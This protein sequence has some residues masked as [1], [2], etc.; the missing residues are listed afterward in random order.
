L[1]F[2]GVSGLLLVFPILFIELY[3]KETFLSKVWFE[4]TW[5]SVFWV[6]E[7]VSASLITDQSNTHLCDDQLQLLATN[8]NHTSPCTSA[9]VL[10]AFT[11]ICAILVFG[12]LSLLSISTIL[13]HKTDPAIF[14]CSVRK[15]PWL[16]VGLR[17]LSST[18]Q[19]PSKDKFH[20]EEPRIVAPKPQRLTI[21]FGE[22]FVA[23]RRGISQEYAIDNFKFPAHVDD[24]YE[25]PGG[26]SALSP[27]V[28]DI[29][30]PMPVATT[31][32]TMRAG[33]SA[34]AYH[35]TREA[36]NPEPAVMR[37]LAPV[38][39]L[40]A[41]YPSYVQHVPVPQP[42]PVPVLEPPRTSGLPPG[43]P[44]VTIRPT[45]PPAAV[46]H[47]PALTLIPS[48]PPPPTQ[49]APAASP[50][51]L[52]DW[53][54]L[55]A[56]AR[57]VKAKRNV[58]P[59]PL[60]AAGTSQ[61]A[62]PAPAASQLASYTFDPAALSAA[63]EPLASPTLA[64]RSRPSGSRPSGPRI[65]STSSGD[66]AQMQSQMHTQRRPPNLN[67]SDISNHRSRDLS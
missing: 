67:L 48:A 56:V 5:I 46:T 23:H 55:N 4:L 31:R 45:R 15:F 7:L 35:H 3:G 49:P 54:R 57:P 52:G 60:P 64:S 32:T 19:S 21:P 26:L 33:P 11:W 40:T 18:P 24:I 1:I 25:T 30:R 62:A 17:Q 44:I 29:E 53:P 12:Y 39:A 34:A 61:P 8:L 66:A 27:D 63:L 14:Q 13:R 28:V 6:L 20:D 41:L 58:K 36:T 51:H 9:Q 65:R 42:V 10:Q 16:S 37:T 2:V 47:P 43:P 59:L 50:S 22:A 38:R